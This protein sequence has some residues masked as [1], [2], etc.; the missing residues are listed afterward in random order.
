MNI[1]NFKKVLIKLGPSDPFPE[2]FLKET[3]L[4]EVFLDVYKN[5]YSVL[6]NNKDFLSVVK[7]KTNEK[8]PKFYKLSENSTKTI[9]QVYNNFH[10]E[11]ILFPAPSGNF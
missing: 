9:Q 3:T 1:E 6:G 11:S 2:S 4:A 7:M 5:Y 10:V 8:P